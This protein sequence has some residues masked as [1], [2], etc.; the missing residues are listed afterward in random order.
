MKVLVFNAGSDSLKFAMFEAGQARTEPLLKGEYRG[1]G[2]AGCTL[3]LT[4]PVARQSLGEGMGA[5]SV[6]EVLPLLPPLLESLSC[7]MP[8]A[9]GHR[10]VHGGDKFTAPALIDEQVIAA[11]EAAIS[12]AP[13]HNPVNLAV[14]RMARHLWPTVPQVA[15]FDTAFHQTMPDY[16]HTYAVP[17]EWRAMGVRRY[18]FHGTSHK[19]V[20]LRT[21][22]SLGRPLQSLRIISCHL[23]NGASLCAIA[24]GL[25]LDTSMGMT[26]LEGLVMGSRAG[27]VDPGVFSY[28]S[29][30]LGLDATQ[31]EQALNRDSG[32]KALAGTHDMRAI[33][34]MAVAGD[35]SAQ[36]AIEVY[37][38]RVRKYVGAY[39]AVMGGLDALVFTGG[40]GEN[41]ATLRRRICEGLG[42]LGL[43]L[44]ER[45]N[46]NLGQAA[47]STNSGDGKGIQSASFGPE[48]DA[49][50]PIQAL[51]SSVAVLVLRTA[52][53]FMIAQETWQ[54][55]KAAEHPGVTKARIPVAVSARHVHL[56]QEAVEAL[57]GKG[58]SL[59][60]EKTL[61]QPEGWAARETVEL[62]GPRGSFPR[63]RV[64]GPTRAAT[65]IEVSRTDTFT[66]GLDVPV[67]ASGDLHDT[68][69]VK[70]RGPA[71]EIETTGLIIAA[72]HIHMHPEDAEGLGLKDGDYVDI[73]LGSGERAVSFANTL[74]RV[75]STYVTE[76]HIDT[77]EANAA[78][79]GR[80]ALGELAKMPLEE[81]ADIVSRKRQRLE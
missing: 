45:G 20:A 25:S 79:I 53:Q 34:E 3:C 16:A 78:G 44:D 6:E 60:L 54:T 71:G 75:K 81:Q 70:L 24:R 76:M 52:E 23:G 47:A 4:H 50:V 40:I 27:D 66:L 35:Q 14:I 29:R 2:A 39:A 61:S 33:E 31:V 48:G 28:L 80:S 59:T 72:R 26:P 21:A 62:I 38:Y 63:V 1:F 64:L 18:G 73:T 55:L 51:D 58:H 19:Y 49:V 17:S 68:P 37:S 5:N 30:T 32:L 13:L 9:V 7:P 8:D 65:Q 42:F 67:R 46:L 41:S 15:V 22:E 56:S 57:F 12:L 43:R 77:D 10:V 69:V 11:I 74:I 36:L